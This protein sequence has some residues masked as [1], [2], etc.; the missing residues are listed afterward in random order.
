VIRVD[1]QAAFWQNQ[2]MN[3]TRLVTFRCPI[4]NASVR[5]DALYDIHKDSMT[6]VIDQKKLLTYSE[7][8]HMQECGVCDVKSQ[9]GFPK[10]RWDKC[11]VNQTGQPVLPVD[12]REV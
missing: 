10:I 6:G 12:A 9:P 1:H 4:V 11:V 5:G 3:V 2:N 7:C 8:S